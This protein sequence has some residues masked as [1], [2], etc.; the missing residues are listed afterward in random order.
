MPAAKRL[1]L[2]GSSDGCSTREWWA[3]E[4]LGPSMADADWPLS[5]SFH[6]TSGYS[7]SDVSGG[8]G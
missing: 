2:R 5:F 6:K 4:L 7:D 8:H 1:F 3:S